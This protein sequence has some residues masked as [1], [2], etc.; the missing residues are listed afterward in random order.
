VVSV[1]SAHASHF[2]GQW[3]SPDGGYTHLDRAIS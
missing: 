2:T 3:L 1:P